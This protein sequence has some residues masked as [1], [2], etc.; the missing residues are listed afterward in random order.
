MPPEQLCSV[1]QD[2]PSGACS[3][4]KEQSQ[5]HGSAARSSCTE[6]LSD[7]EQQARPAAAAGR[8]AVRKLHIPSE[9]LTGSCPYSCV[10]CC[11]RNVLVKFAQRIQRHFHDQPSNCVGKRSYFAVAARSMQDED[12]H[13]RGDGSRDEIFVES[14]ESFEVTANIFSKHHKQQNRLR[15]AHTAGF[16]QRIESTVSSTECSS[17]STVRPNP[18]CIVLVLYCLQVA[19]ENDSLLTTGP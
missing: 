9:V 18:S 1:R 13:C 15:R 6:Y 10:K 7:V 8:Q 19:T 4:D 14:V 3:H 12:V 16:V 2:E 17:N 11:V 5:K